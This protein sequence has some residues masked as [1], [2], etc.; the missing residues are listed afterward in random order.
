MLKGESPFLQVD[1]SQPATKEQEFKILSLGSSSSTTLV[2]SPTRAF[3]PKVEG[4]I[5]MTMEVSELLSWVALDTSGHAS[6]SSDPKRLESLA[7]A[8]SLSLKLEDSTKL[9][10]TSS[11]VSIPND[12]DID[13][14]TLEEI[15]ASPSHP[16]GTPELSRDTLP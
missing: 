11:Q 2:A 12:M 3:L 6:G 9:V 15:N 7:L 1:L 4:Q 13:N 16:D 5:S 8:I 14:P 10:D